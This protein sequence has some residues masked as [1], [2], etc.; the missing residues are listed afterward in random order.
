MQFWL[1]TGGLSHLFP[2]PILELQTESELHA[3]REVL[4]RNGDPA[5]TIRG[6]PGVRPLINRRIECVESF[7][8]QLEIQALANLEVLEQRHVD[9]RGPGVADVREAVVITPQR[10][11]VGQ[12]HPDHRFVGARAVVARAP[13]KRWS[14]CS[15]PTPT[16]CGV[17]TTASRTSATP[18]PRRSTCPCSRTSRFASA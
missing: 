9:L 3:A 13:T 14:G 4:L 18:G 12:L 16:R 6:Q 10:V 8:A 7:A 1:H 11:G 17:M 15:C 5:E 2:L